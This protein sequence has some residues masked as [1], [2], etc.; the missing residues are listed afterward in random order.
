MCVLSSRITRSQRLVMRSLR[1]LSN[2][3]DLSLSYQSSLV[4]YRKPGAGFPE[5]CT[6][7]IRVQLRDAG[8]HEAGPGALCTR[9]ASAPLGQRPLPRSTCWG[10]SLPPH[11]RCSD[12]LRPRPRPA[13]G[14][15]PHQLP[16]LKAPAPPFAPPAKAQGPA[17][18]SHGP[19]R[20]Q[21]GRAHASR[22]PGAAR[23]RPGRGPG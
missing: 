21:H 8:A 14:P 18:S 5:K 23:R 3:A 22:A 12:A 6:H 15:A 20:R 4:S 1:A 17:G 9:D 11:L 13:P 10:R 2:K 19:L 7:G 16:P